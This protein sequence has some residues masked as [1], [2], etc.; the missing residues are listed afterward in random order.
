MN[1][2][3]SFREK[4]DSATASDYVASGA[5]SW[6]SGMFLF[7]ASSMR[8]EMEACLPGL[9]SDVQSAVA[10]GESDLDFQRI[11]AEHFSKV[12][13]ISIDYGVMERSAKV[14]VVPASMG[15]S[16]LGS[17]A[18]LHRMGS[19]DSQGNT[20]VGPV[21]AQDCDNSYLHSN[22]T[23]L[24]AQGLSGAAVIATDDAILVTSLASD[25]KVKEM[26]AALKEQDRIEATQHSTYYRPWGSYR[27]IADGNGFQVKE[28][29]VYPGKRLSLQLHHKRAEHWVIVAG[30]AVVTRGMDTLHL[31]AN[32]S[33]YIPVETK[34][35]LENTGETDLRLIE[36]QSGSYLG[37]D[38]I[39]RFDDDFGREGSTKPY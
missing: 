38:D 5:Y 9:L 18:A 1:A 11:S 33:V 20:C 2:V 17:Y 13:D 35:R 14:A 27:S 30:E 29:V 22:G 26:V 8:A 32:Q 36:V 28:I 39:V 24:T 7:K 34:H 37:E 3:A 4:P 31:E 12:Q 15:W 10:A 21:V 6:N 25:Q 16:D 23:L 19:P